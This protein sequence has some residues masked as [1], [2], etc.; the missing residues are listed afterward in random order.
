MAEAVVGK[1]PRPP[2]VHTP[3]IKGQ[4][5]CL[6]PRCH[7]G[8]G[9]PSGSWCPAGTRQVSALCATPPVLLPHGLGG[10]G[11]SENSSSMHW[12]AGGGEGP[13]S[14]GQQGYPRSPSMT[15]TG[16]GRAGQGDRGAKGRA[17]LWLTTALSS[18][19]QQGTAAR[20]SGQPVPIAGPRGTW[21]T[22]PSSAGPNICSAASPV[23]LRPPF[24]IP[25]KGR[26]DVKYP[27]AHGSTFSG[28]DGAGRP[29]QGAGGP[30]PASGPVPRLKEEGMEEGW[31]GGEGGR[32]LSPT[33]RLLRTASGHSQPPTR[34]A[35]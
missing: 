34:W 25:C 20:E 26:W 6:P 29:S 33:L 32:Q 28:A 9:V 31:G 16:R 1:T 14:W 12:C 23:P 2:D 11:H 13:R 30:R 35:H 17:G 7:Q 5:L 18:K 24:L 8:C 15:S 3:L 4:C 22:T 21:L 19:Q 10:E 27:G